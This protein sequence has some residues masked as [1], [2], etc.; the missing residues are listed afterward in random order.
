[1]HPETRPALIYSGLPID[2]Y[3]R[4]ERASG[5]RAM[6]AATLVLGALLALELGS[7]KAGFGRPFWGAVSWTA[8]AVG[9]ATLGLQTIASVTRGRVGAETVPAAVCVAAVF[10]GGYLVPAE[11]AFLCLLGQCLEGFTLRRVHKLCNR[12]REYRPKKARVAREGEEAEISPEALAVGD[13]LVIRPG[14]RVAADGVVV[15]GSSA[16]DES[17]LDGAGLPATKMEGDS[18]YAGTLNHFGRLEV[19]VKKVGTRTMLAKL[20]RL[21]DEARRRKGP[22][23]KSAEDHARFLVWAVAVAA[24]A[25]FMATNTAGLRAWTIT[26][27]TP[28]FDWW[29]ALA[30][31][32]LA[33]FRS[34]P[35]AATTAIRVASARLALRGVLVKGGDAIERLAKVDAVAFGMTGTLTEGRPEFGRLL[36]FGGVDPDDVLRLAASAEQPSAHPLAR[37]LVSVSKGRGM[38]LAGVADYQAFPGAGVSSALFEGDGRRV[39]VGSPEF[40]RGQGLWISAEAGI[41]LDSLEEAGETAILVGVDGRVVGAFGARDPLRAGAGDAIQALRSLGLN[42]LTILT[43]E[44]PAK[45]RETAGAADVGRIEAGLN[46][47]GKGDWV[48]R[49]KAEGRVIAFVGDGVGDVP[50]LAEADVGFALSGL[51]SDVGSAAGSVVVTG[52]P[53][54]A[55]PEAIRL[56]RRALRVIRRNTLIFALGMT[57]LG[58]VLVG[59]RVIGPVGA[60]ALSQFGSLLALWNATQFGGSWWREFL[61]PSGWFEVFYRSSL[62]PTWLGWARERRRWVPGKTLAAVVAAGYLATGFTAIHPYEAGLV[63]G[64]G[65]Y[66][67]PLLRP[68]LHWTLP[69]PLEAVTRFEPDLV[70]LAG[71]GGWRASRGTGGDGSSLYVTGDENLVELSAVVEY[72]LTEENAADLMFGVASVEAGVSAAAEGAFLEAVARSTLDDI[73]GSGRRGL[74]VEVESKLRDRLAQKELKVVVEAVRVTDTRPP[75]EAGPAYRDA[76]AANSDAARYRNEARAYATNQI[77]GARAEARARRAS[78][79]ALG[80]GYKTRAEGDRQAFLARVSP[81]SARPDLTEF[82]LW[83]DTLAVALAGRPKLLLDP[84]AGGR[85]HVSLSAGTELAPVP[86]WE[87]PGPRSGTTREE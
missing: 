69:W 46:P 29:P 20:I 56:A 84:K 13:R 48:R 44:R 1:V 68:G 15:A 12:T 24:A 83:W 77:W 33:S 23:E 50:A 34:L 74:E 41:G 51:G 9:V 81:H 63:R 66:R 35:P 65:A 49:R 38:R 53:V 55:L 26:G 39:M 32:V 64:F 27:L 73:L 11:V 3:D 18:V 43:A 10:L 25:V 2:R 67:P 7:E 30:V 76:S 31:L 60:A 5:W 70:R 45:A 58:I 47:A 19:R 75:R 85:G 21:Q 87:T 28:S 36:A 16:V 57:T 54:R 71:V 86:S 37:M 52:D 14:E 17:V 59:L 22:L 8:S 78:A 79:S 80:H 42:D 62:L 4:E 72:R 82:R 40:V 61:H 6:T